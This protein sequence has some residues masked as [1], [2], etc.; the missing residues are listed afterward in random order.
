MDDA[1][2]VSVL[3]RLTHRHEQFQPL[4]RCEL[5]GVAIFGD[6]RSFHQLHNEVGPTALGGPRIKHPGDI[7]MIH[8]RQCLPFGLETGQHGLRVHPGLDH[9]D[10]DRPLHGFSLLGHEDA[11]HPTLADLLDQLVLAAEDGPD[12]LAPAG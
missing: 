6:R 3:D 1:L 7:G 12:M 10:R 4:P 5:S 11:A 9:L 2:L 8:H